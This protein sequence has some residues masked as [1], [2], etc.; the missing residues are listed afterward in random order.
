[1]PAGVNLNF[2]SRFLEVATEAAYP[3]YALH[4]TTIFIV[5]FSVV[6]WE[7]G[8]LINFATIMVASLAATSWCTTCW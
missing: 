8:V 2:T 6:G 7:T 5:G 4:Q 3:V 1:M